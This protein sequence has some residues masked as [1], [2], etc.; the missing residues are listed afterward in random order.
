MKKL[1]ITTVLSGLLITQNACNQEYL[2]PSTASQPQVVSSADGL[3]TVC[4]SLQYRYSVGGGGSVLGSAVTASGL[5]TN[6]MIV[7]NQGNGEEFALQQGQANVTNSNGVVR[8]IWTQAQLLRSNAD[9]VLANTGVVNDPGTKSGIVAYASIFRALALGTLAQFF[10]SA[11]IISQDNSPFVER[12]QLLKEAI[13][14]LETAATMVAANPVSANF[15]GKVPAGIDIPNTLQALIARYALFAGDNDKALAAAAK[16]DLTKKSVFNFDDNSRN[17]FFL[18]AFSNVNVVA[19]TNV[20]LGLSGAL[21]PDPADK[22]IAFYTQTANTKANLGT[23]FYTANN[24]PIPLYLPGEVLLIQAEASARKGDLAGAV[25]AL[26]KVLT[27]TAA[28]DI[29][30]L[31]AGLPA[32][33]GPQTADAILLEILRN[34]NIELAYSGF[35]LEDSRRFS[36]PGPG[37]AGSERT[38]NF[39][40]YPRTE[41][42]NNTQTPATDPS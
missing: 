31:G 40:P 29:Y 23:G 12:A 21:Q 11:P 35:R 19:P 5:T 4:N 26:N 25:T 20:N 3:I 7:L 10:Q 28:T 30:G 1:L 6:E 16:V 2:N 33:S 18:Y 14:S 32:Y 22:R 34:R 37:A 17:P 24:S 27:K 39:Y 15:T 38:R 41:R 13:T 42:D 8:T 36:R 9:L